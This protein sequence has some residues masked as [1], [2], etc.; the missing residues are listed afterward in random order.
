[1]NTNCAICDIDLN[2]DFANR[3]I[4]ANNEIVCANCL[5]KGQL[6]FKQFFRLKKVTVEEVKQGIQ[7]AGHNII[8]FDEF[9]PTKKISDYV[10][11]DDKNKKWRLPK[12]IQQTVYN[13]SDIID[14]ELIEDGK[15]VT[16]GGLGRAL[17]GGALFGGAGA[18]VGAV[19]GRK[20]NAK[21]TIL[22][23]KVTLN[24]SETSSIYI[25]FIERETK[26]DS[27]EYGNA[28]NHA[29]ECMS[30]FQIICNQQ[31]KV[32]NQQS[33]TNPADEIMKYKNLL[34]VGAITEDEY[35][36]KKKEILGI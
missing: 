8:N 13:Y 28:L 15:T 34:D 3:R 14:F 36:K 1:M 9:I 20:T 33:S 30:T 26:K 10:H 22:T 2:F 19:T 5:S 18:V 21:C 25:N 7:N 35:N 17:V 23:V 24:F 4:L 12:S 11:F 32:P 31:Q 29:Q 16:N 27:I 6:S